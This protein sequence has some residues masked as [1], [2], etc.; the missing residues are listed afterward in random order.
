MPQGRSVASSFLVMALVM[1]KERAAATTAKIAGS[2]APTPGRTMISTPTKPSA[3]AS[4]RFRLSRSPSS[5]TAVSA[6][7][8]GEVNSTAKTMAS[9]S[10]AMARI[11]STWPMK[12]TEWRTSCMTGWQERRTAGSAR[13][14]KS[15]MKATPKRLR[16][17]R[18]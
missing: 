16:R 17:S 12:C 3:M 1:P 9:G 5:S 11:Q 15:P 2:N 13:A 7:Q 18:I 10:Q 4:C 8:M 14:M 6:P